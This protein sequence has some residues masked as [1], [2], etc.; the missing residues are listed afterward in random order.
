[1]SQA[2]VVLK[3]AES[4]LKYACVSTNIEAECFFVGSNDL[5]LDKID[6]EMKY[7]NGRFKTNEIVELQKDCLIYMIIENT[8]KLIELPIIKLKEVL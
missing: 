3:P 4:T 1:L 5:L 7:I 6:L 8:Q 2:V